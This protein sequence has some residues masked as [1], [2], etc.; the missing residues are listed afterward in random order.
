MREHRPLPKR[1]MKHKF[2]KN[3]EDFITKTHDPDTAYHRIKLNLDKLLKEMNNDIQPQPEEQLSSGV[4][5]P[6]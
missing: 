5:T 2:R 3:L 6:A 1:L 4:R